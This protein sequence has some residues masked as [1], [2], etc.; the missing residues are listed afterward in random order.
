[1]S[2]QSNINQGLSLAALLAT[3]NPSLQALAK[4][5]QEVSRLTKQK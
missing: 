4:K 5:R 3:Q 2:I 1:M